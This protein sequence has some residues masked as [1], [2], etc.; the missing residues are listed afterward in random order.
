[1]GKKLEFFKNINIFAIQ[2]KSYITEFWLWKKND[3]FEKFWMIP[4]D[5]Y[6]WEG[7]IFILTF[8]TCFLRL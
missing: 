6:T 2:S 4:N 3:F 7:Q 1:M 5:K 8:I